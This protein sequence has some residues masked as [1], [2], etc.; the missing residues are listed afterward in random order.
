MLQIQAFCRAF[1]FIFFTFFISAPALSQWKGANIAPVL[2]EWICNKVDRIGGYERLHFVIN[3]RPGAPTG[4]AD[5]NL[6]TVE[7]RENVG[8]GKIAILRKYQGGVSFDNRSL[9]FGP[10]D[11]YDRGI[12]RGSRPLRLS[13][14]FP[15]GDFGVVTNVLLSD[16][17]ITHN[18][19]VGFQE[20]GK[21]G[22][23][24]C[25]RQ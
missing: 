5:V 20:H 14:I 11:I 21:L 2:G 25:Q 13:K 3:V 24:E 9:W 4:V 12:F 17:K 15:R 22:K 16:I 19:L 1:T 23:M 10:L 6:A 7:V 18:R 8:V